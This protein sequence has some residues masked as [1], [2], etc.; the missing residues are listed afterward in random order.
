MSSPASLPVGRTSAARTHLDVPRRRGEGELPVGMLRQ[1]GE[2][3]GSLLRWALLGM[4]RGYQLTL[5]HM[6]PPACRFQPTC[7][8][9]AYTAIERHG[10]IRGSWL[11]IRRLARCHPF[12]GSGYDPVP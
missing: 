8:R 5:S 6:I 7:S 9:Y 3:L 11:A 4:I 10:A 12:G 1:A 2:F